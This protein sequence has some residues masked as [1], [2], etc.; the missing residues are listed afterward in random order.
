[1]AGVVNIITKKAGKSTT[2]TRE[3]RGRHRGTRSTAPARQTARSR[4]R[5]TT[6]SPAPTSPTGIAT[7]RSTSAND[8]TG[9]FDLP[10]AE[11]LNGFVK[12]GHHGDVRQRSGSLS[13]ADIAAFGRRASVLGR[14][15]QR[16]PERQQS[17]STSA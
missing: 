5:S 16:Q 14:L 3:P 8:F 17:I 6:C 1:M 13:L 9:R 15:A 4:A 11:G 12:V 7:T 10:I 2:G